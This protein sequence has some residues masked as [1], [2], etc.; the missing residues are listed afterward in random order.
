MDSHSVWHITGYYYS[1]NARYDIWYMTFLSPT[2]YRFDCIHSIPT[3]N[4]RFRA[5]AKPKNTVSFVRVVRER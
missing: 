5:L 1:Y 4:M 3:M 2:Q